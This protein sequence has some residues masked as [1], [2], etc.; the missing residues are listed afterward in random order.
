MRKKRNLL[1]VGVRINII[2]SVHVHKTLHN[3]NTILKFSLFVKRFLSFSFLRPPQFD[4]SLQVPFD[5]LSHLQDFVEGS[6]KIF[7]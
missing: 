4:E 7:P 1:T 6:L 2:D 3:M 5:S